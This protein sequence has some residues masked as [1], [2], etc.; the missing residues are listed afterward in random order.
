MADC[1]HNE[2]GNHDC[3]PN[4]ECVR[5]T[6]V[7]G[8]YGSGVEPANLVHNRANGILSITYR[9]ETRGVCDD[10]FGDVEA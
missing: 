10:A 2:W 1:N 6:C 8:G 9:G 5:L 4:T 3:N 7:G